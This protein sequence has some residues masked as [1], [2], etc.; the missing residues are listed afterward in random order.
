MDLVMIKSKKCTW[1]HLFHQFWQVAIK[2]EIAVG[3]Y[4]ISIHITYVTICQT[5]DQTESHKK[6][7]IIYTLYTIPMRLIKK[8]VLNK[9]PKSPQIVTCKTK[10]RREN[11]AKSEMCVSILDKILVLKKQAKKVT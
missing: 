5:K 3:R 7:F 1:L 11:C 10:K 2:F 8:N 9:F 4:Q 6:K